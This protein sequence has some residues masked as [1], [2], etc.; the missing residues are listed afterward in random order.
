[1]CTVKSILLEFFADFNQCMVDFVEDNKNLRICSRDTKN[2]LKFVP[3]FLFFT[4]NMI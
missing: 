2:C 3:V 4:G 1:L